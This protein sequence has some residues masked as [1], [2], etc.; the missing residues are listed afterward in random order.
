MRQAVEGAGAGIGVGG[1]FGS[2][3][4]SAPGGSSGRYAGSG[5]LEVWREAHIVPVTRVV[6]VFPREAHGA[7]PPR[8]ASAVTCASSRSSNREVIGLQP[9][10]PV[11]EAFPRAANVVSPV[12]GASPAP[13]APLGSAR[14]ETLGRQSPESSAV[15]TAGLQRLGRLEDGLVSIRTELAELC[16][17]RAAGRRE[18]LEAELRDLRPACDELARAKHLAQLAAD[19]SSKLANGCDELQR[20]R[21][22][23]R[24]SVVELG[25]ESGAGVSSSVSPVRHW[26]GDGSQIVSRDRARQERLDRLEDQLQ[27]LLPLQVQLP[28]AKEELEA[29][30]AKGL[31]VGEELQFAEQM[32]ARSEVARQ[33][34][35]VELAHVRGELV[36]VDG[37]L[38]WHRD[39]LERVRGEL[40]NARAECQALQCQSAG[41]SEDALKI[42]RLEG[43]LRRL[44]PMERQLLETT[45]ELE[46]A[47]EESRRSQAELARTR[48]QL[49]EF[50]AAE[51]EW[52]QVRD[53]LARAREELARRNFERTREC[54]DASG[55]A[56]MVVP[57]ASSSSPPALAA[58]CDAE[59]PVDEL[60]RAR[61]ELARAEAERTRVREDRA[62]AAAAF[63]AE[64]ELQDAAAFLSEKGSPATPMDR[65]WTMT[66]P[67]LPPAR[68]SPAWCVLGGGSLA[69]GPGSA[70]DTITASG[71][72]GYDALS[73]SE[74]SITPSQSAS[75]SNSP[76]P[77]KV[78]AQEQSAQAVLHTASQPG[79]SSLLT[80]SAALPP[81]AFTPQ[82]VSAISAE[83]TTGAWA[84]FDEFPTRSSWHNSQPVAD[85]ASGINADTSREQQVMSKSSEIVLET[86]LQQRGVRRDS[87]G[88]QWSSRSSP[89]PPPADPQMSPSSNLTAFGS[90]GGFNP[91]NP[92]SSPGSA[93]FVA[94]LKPGFSSTNPFAT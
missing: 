93:G 40:R 42:D 17:R 77:A 31:R 73:G 49:S 2:T 47:M 54:Q 1:Q 72:D 45:Q 44:R 89:V 3:A 35:Q 16:G 78:R 41:T 85:A 37:E 50:S 15:P 21:S 9:A 84:K 62:A 7:S 6:E 83:A 67:Q 60:S 22:A 64:V 86:M 71:C 29:A 10:V 55:L 48:E 57:A 68:G 82:D 58:G 18:R 94:N 14:H 43:E 79:R 63:L 80:A 75:R 65:P 70:P 24:T 23:G 61:E 34:T 5:A 13:G 90:A 4:S 88:S 56:E 19:H 53:E 69:S 27:K 25:A 51:V 91:T 46:K 66:G 76:L 30:E 26:S 87:A 12:R 28:R 33:G 52:A 38:R 59:R 92:F 11:S 8:G 36:R 20:A 32:A 39:E 74:E 81:A